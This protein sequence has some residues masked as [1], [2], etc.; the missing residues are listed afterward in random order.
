MIVEHEEVVA[1]EDTA[2]LKHL[3]DAE[4]NIKLSAINKYDEIIWKV[5]TGYLAILY[6]GLTFLVGEAGLKNLEVLPTRPVTTLSIGFL[7]VGFSLS[8]F[9]LDLGFNQ[10]KLRTIV[11]RDMLIEIAHDPKRSCTRVQ[12]TKLLRVA[13]ERPLGK[14]FPHAHCEYQEKLRWNLR[15]GFSCRSM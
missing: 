3:L 9:L 5:R 1:T 12:C 4:L 8:A 15:C 7:I 13:A 14:H 6:A 10:K 11:I 2:L